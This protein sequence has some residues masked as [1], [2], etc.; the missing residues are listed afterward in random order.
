MTGP[1][2]QMDYGASST[3]TLE[4]SNN[5][6]AISAGLSGAYDVYHLQRPVSWGQPA[7]EAEIVAHLPG[8]PERPVIFAYDTGSLMYEGHV[9][10]A[11]RVGFF[12]QNQAAN[13]LTSTGWD[14]FDAAVA[15]AIDCDIPSNGNMAVNFGNE[16]NTSPNPNQLQNPNIELFPNPA[17]DYIAVNLPTKVGSEVTVA[18]FDYYGRLVKTVQID[19]VT[20]DPF[21][22][23]LSDAPNGKLT[24][25]TY[26]N[27]QRSVS[28]TFLIIR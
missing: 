6:H 13:L 8:N 12:L 22:I 24:L 9:A 1:N 5:N 10:P 18:I 19:E 23:D 2:N 21:Y 17:V 14:L 3:V 4:V 11:R 25:Q 7:G 20:E 27:G 16:D 26:V 15:W 28:S